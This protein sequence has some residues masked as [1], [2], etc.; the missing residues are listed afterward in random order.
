MST[1]W[2]DLEWRD[3]PSGHPQSRRVRHA[4]ETTRKSRPGTNLRNTAD[5]PSGK[6][7]SDPN[8]SGPWQRR[9]ALRSSLGRAEPPRPKRCAEA[10]LMITEEGAHTPRAAVRFTTPR[11][12]FGVVRRENEYRVDRGRRK[13]GRTWSAHRNCG[14][15]PSGLV[16]AR[17]VGTTVSVR[18][19]RRT[20]SSPTR[21]FRGLMQRV[22][23]LAAARVGHQQS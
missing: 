5:V 6:V 17:G 20:T 23:T 9:R 1:P 11:Q 3:R 22:A 14:S 15:R 4:A 8:G 2:R 13:E 21:L 12:V 16:E 10:R 7:R 19:Q 18:S